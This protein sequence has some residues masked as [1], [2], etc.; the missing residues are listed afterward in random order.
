MVVM[1]ELWL[2]FDYVQ[3]YPSGGLLDLYGTASTFE[4]AVEMADNVP[5]PEER[6]WGCGV[7]Q[8]ARL[9][10]PRVLV[11]EEV[12]VRLVAKSVWEDWEVVESHD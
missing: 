11:R 5:R 2:V 4:E 6:S 8:I 7:Q 1:D 3:W 12:Y 10:D 9:G